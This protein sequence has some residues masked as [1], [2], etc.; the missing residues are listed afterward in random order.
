MRQVFV[1]LAGAVLIAALAASAS[2]R[3]GYQSAPRAAS[4][5]SAGDNELRF[6]CDEGDA[7]CAETAD[8]IGYEGRYTGHDEPS[9]LFYDD[10][11]GAGNNN[12][13]RFV[14]PKDPPIKPKQ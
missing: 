6:R 3:T 5:V 2:A 13:Y 9:A 11:S 12:R 7:L 1:L 14:V 8:A 10:R 4:A